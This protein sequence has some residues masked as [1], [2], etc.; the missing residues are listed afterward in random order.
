[1]HLKESSHG[2]GSSE[3]VYEIVHLTVKLNGN[4][5]QEQCNTP[6]SLSSSEVKYS[7]I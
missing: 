1:M 4:I 7:C 3:N 5:M 6:A 2:V